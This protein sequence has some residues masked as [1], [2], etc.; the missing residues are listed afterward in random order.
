MIPKLLLRDRLAPPK[1]HDAF[2]EVLDAQPRG[3]CI[4]VFDAA[5]RTDRYI[6]VTAIHDDIYAGKRDAASRGQAAFQPCG[7]TGRRGTP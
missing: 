4:K 1:I 2:W 6:K 7:A 3:A 5:E